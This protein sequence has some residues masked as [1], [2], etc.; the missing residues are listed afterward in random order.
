MKYYPGI[1]HRCVIQKPNFDSSNPSSSFICDETGSILCTV[2]DGDTFIDS[3]NDAVTLLHE[4]AYA[5]SKA[6]PTAFT[7]FLFSPPPDLS[8]ESL[9]SDGASADYYFLPKGALQLQD[10]ISHC[11]MNAQIGEIFRACYRY[12]RAPHSPQLRDAK[13]ILFYAEAEVKRLKK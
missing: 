13:K 4:M 2:Q 7:N 12:G 8:E 6:S 5:F 3:Y 10:L 1:Q 11:D 9:P